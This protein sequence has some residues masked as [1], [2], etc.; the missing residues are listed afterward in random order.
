MPLVNGAAVGVLLAGEVFPTDERL[1]FVERCVGFLCRSA[2][3][4]ALAVFPVDDVALAVLGQDPK[5]LYRFTL[6]PVEIGDEVLPPL[7]MGSHP[8]AIVEQYEEHPADK[9]CNNHAGTSSRSCAATKAW[10]RFATAIASV[11][12]DGS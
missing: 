8:N 7:S 4:H 11:L 12:S 10:M 2:R 1:R 5:Q 3:R 9:K 6:A